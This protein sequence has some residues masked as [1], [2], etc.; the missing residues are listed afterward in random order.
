VAVY[1]DR[2]PLSEAEPGTAQSGSVAG[3]DDARMEHTLGSGHEAPG[4][5][6]ATSKPGSKRGLS[7]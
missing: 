3:W 2:H 7:G 4:D 6:L 1:L 5:T